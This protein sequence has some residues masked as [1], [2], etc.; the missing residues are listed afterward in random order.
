MIGTR[1]AV[2]DSTRRTAR[3]HNA[4]TIIKLFRYSIK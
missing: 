2:E 3:R 1:L 4:V